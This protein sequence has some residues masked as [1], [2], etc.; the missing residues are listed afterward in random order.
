[1]LHLLER[2][3]LGRDRKGNKAQC[4][5]GDE[6]KESLGKAAAERAIDSRNEA[7]ESS[8]PRSRRRGPEQRLRRPG[9]GGT[10]RSDG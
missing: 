7:K 8:I 6:A 4:G 1:M 3:G 9:Q 10:E 2:G 5:L